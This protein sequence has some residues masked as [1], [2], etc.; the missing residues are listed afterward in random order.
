MAIGGNRFLLLQGYGASGSTGQDST[1]AQGIIS[2]SLQAVL[3]YPL[4]SSSASLYCAHILL[5][6]RLFLVFTTFLFLLVVPRVLE[7]LSLPQEWP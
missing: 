5:F 4:V 1:K 6:L 3:H 7:Y 2:Y